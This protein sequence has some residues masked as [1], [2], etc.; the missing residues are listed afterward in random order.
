MPAQ[1]RCFGNIVWRLTCA[2]PALS[3]DIKWIAR[4]RILAGDV[5]VSRRWRHGLLW[6]RHNG[7]NWCARLRIGNTADQ[8]GTCA[9]F[10]IRQSAG[11]VFQYIMHTPQSPHALREMWVQ[12]AMKNRVA[13]RLVAVTAAAVVNRVA[14]SLLRRNRL[15]VQIGTGIGL[16][17]Q[18]LMGVQVKNMRFL[19]TG[20]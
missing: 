7:W 4:H 1:S 9:Q 5:G 17:R 2:L 16:L 15:R 19:R 14:E 6:Q 10:P 18:P 20:M 11:A 12:M 8:I 13:R 3:G